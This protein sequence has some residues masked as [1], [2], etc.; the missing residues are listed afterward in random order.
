MQEQREPAVSLEPRE[1][2]LSEFGTLVMPSPGSSK[3][4]VIS[5]CGIRC[6]CMSDLLTTKGKNSFQGQTHKVHYGP[7]C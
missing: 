2:A 1:P 6:H 3:G 5:R 7:L 4:P